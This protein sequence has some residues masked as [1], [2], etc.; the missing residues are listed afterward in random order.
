[1][2]KNSAL[3]VA[4]LSCG[5]MFYALVEVFRALFTDNSV[6]L[7]GVGFVISMFIAVLFYVKFVDASG[8]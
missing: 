3:A 2:D 5:V 7:P 1:M 8:R 6:L 4:L